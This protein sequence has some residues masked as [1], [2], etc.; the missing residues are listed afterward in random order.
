MV[1]REVDEN[2]AIFLGMRN[3]ERQANEA[4]RVENSDEFDN[5]TGTYS[6]FVVF[7]TCY[8]DSFID[9]FNECM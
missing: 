5:S 7:G 8:V 3:A 2:L 4:L 1:V 9:S 6:I